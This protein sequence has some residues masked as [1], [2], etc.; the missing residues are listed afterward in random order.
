RGR[1]ARLGELDRSVRRMLERDPHRRLGNAGEVRDAIAAIRL[2]RQLPETIELPHESRSVA[3]AGFSNISGNPEDDWLGAGIAE[4]LTADAGQL[5]GV[6]V[7]SRER[8]AEILKRLAEQ[9]GDGDEHL[10]LR[11]GREL[12]ARWG[13]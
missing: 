12:R 4:T 10:F 6:S 1:D 2:G 7:I 3:V 13:A 8:V 9:T 11:A 5:E